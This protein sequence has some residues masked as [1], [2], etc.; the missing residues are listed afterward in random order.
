MRGPALA[1]IVV[2]IIVIAILGM[3]FADQDMPGHLDRPP[4]CF[5]LEPARPG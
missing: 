3:R 5:G 4:G 2:A 1:V